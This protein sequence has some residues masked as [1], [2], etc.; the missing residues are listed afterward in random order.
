[1]LVDNAAMSSLDTIQS[2]LERDS[3]RSLEKNDTWYLLSCQWMQQCRQLCEQG[4]NTIP[5]DNSDLIDNGIRV[6]TSY[7]PPKQ[8]NEGTVVEYTQHEYVDFNQQR[9]S[10]TYVYS[11]ALKRS[12]QENYNFVYVS[13][14]SWIQLV[15][16]F[17]VLDNHTIE[18]RVIADG[19]NEQVKRIELYPYLIHLLRV[20]T[21]TYLPDPASEVLILLSKKSLV[22]DLKIFGYYALNLLY[23]FDESKK[24]K[25]A[26]EHDKISTI[27]KNIRLWNNL[28]AAATLL[29]NSKMS[30]SL[31]DALLVDDQRI[32]VEVPVNDVWP[33]DRLYQKQKQ[34]QQPK[35]PQ[36]RSDESSIRDTSDDE[37]GPPLSKKKKLAGA[38]S[39][40]IDYLK[41]KFTRA[42]SP[43]NTAP[44][45]SKSSKKSGLCGLKNLGNTCFMNSALQ[46]LSN[47]TE[48]TEYFLTG[49][50]SNDINKVNPLGSKGKLAKEFANLMKEMWSGVAYV[51]PINFKHAIGQFAPQF[52]GFAQHD[53]QE[54]IAYLL[55][56][57]HEDLNKV[58]DKPVVELQEANGRPDDVVAQE[59]WNHHLMR[60]RSV[61]VDLFQGQLKSTLKCPDCQRIS[62]KFDPFMYLSVPIPHTS[63]VVINVIFMDDLSQRP[64]KFCIEMSNNQTVGV[65]KQKF[66]D[67]FNVDS[68]R[69][70]FA[71]MNGYK[72]NSIMEDSRPMSV[73]ASKK[74]ILGFYT[75]VTDTPKKYTVTYVTQR[76]Y[77]QED[78]TKKPC[79]IPLVLFVD[80][81]TTGR[82]LY[83][84]VWSHIQRYSKQSVQM[85]LQQEQQNQSS[86]ELLPNQKHQIRF[87]FDVNKPL[88]SLHIMN[89]AAYSC[90][91]EQCTNRECDGCLIPCTEDPVV[92]P[93][94]KTI[95]VQ[96]FT[97]DDFVTKESMTVNLD[98]SVNT[99]REKMNRQITLEDC[100]NT[101]SEMEQL[102]PNDP[103]Y[104]P[105]CR[106]LKQAYK[107]FEIWSAPEIL[108]IHLKRFV[109]DRRYRERIDKLI[110]FP[111]ERMDM[112]RFMVR[113]TT[114]PLLYDLYAISNHMGTLGGGHYIAHA[115][116]ADGNWYSYNDSHCSRVSESNLKS[117]SAYLLFYRRRRHIADMSVQLD[118]DK[119]NTNGTSSM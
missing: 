74:Q 92:F 119:L 94:N 58:K 39:L 41:T 7:T 104:C 43:R 101:F 36:K 29:D 71:D 77:S 105:N 107:K 72:V 23:I 116:N 83:E 30:V 19:M 103:W 90:G 112:S 3:K 46:C 59:A 96:W 70:L 1:M 26:I 57:L 51:A 109:Y 111:I 86:S 66:A 114:E 16:M 21:S 88:F 56:G 6:V 22:S 5:I 18:R 10:S 75:P 64:K 69:L 61:I 95:T 48:L 20:N 113:H 49:K 81:N 91:N 17:G 53:S 60:N 80:T 93:E 42:P 84:L 24:L 31:E 11:I 115:K 32:I 76:F 78:D 63:T 106:D 89:D 27:Q 62:I 40:N 4:A 65:L 117:T 8:S 14:E 2:L 52:S 108:V 118:L 99:C 9:H 45:S 97:A 100:L 33:F 110:D 38:F 15:N 25:L 12:L 28:T 44:T 34:Q 50:Y 73:V 54:L 35:S 55:D 67:E 68:K 47:T 37:D 85:N 13:S 87:A 98:P 102:G 82:G 79:G